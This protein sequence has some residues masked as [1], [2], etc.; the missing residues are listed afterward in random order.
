MLAKM[1]AKREV[2]YRSLGYRAVSNAELDLGP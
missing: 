1:A 2:G